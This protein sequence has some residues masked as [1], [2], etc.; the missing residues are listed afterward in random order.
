MWLGSNCM[1]DTHCAVTCVGNT[2]SCRRLR[3][4]QSPGMRSGTELMARKKMQTTVCKKLLTAGRPG[5]D[6]WD[7]EELACFF[8]QV[9]H[10]RHPEHCFMGHV[11][12]QYLAG[13][14]YG[15]LCALAI[16]FKQPAASRRSRGRAVFF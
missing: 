16:L 6:L 7:D 13:P 2:L 4:R 14:Y 8:P 3:H 9:S 15:P 5:R 1:M 12:P 11:R 10:M